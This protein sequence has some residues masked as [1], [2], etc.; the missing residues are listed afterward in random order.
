M[1]GQCLSRNCLVLLRHAD[2]LLVILEGMLDTPV[3]RIAV[4]SEF[5][6]TR[7]FFH[8]TNYRKSTNIDS[9]VR[10]GS[11]E[12]KMG[13]RKRA[14]RFCVSLVTCG[15]TR[16]IAQLVP[17]VCRTRRQKRREEKI[18]ILSCKYIEHHG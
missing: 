16:Q 1:K 7:L 13:F 17:R 14:F 11:P 12:R 18:L 5:N 3:I 15:D 4:I 10:Y 2:K 6:G 9:S 8:E